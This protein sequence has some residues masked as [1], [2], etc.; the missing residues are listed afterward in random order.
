MNLIMAKMI[1]KY[2][3]EM[4]DQGLNWHDDSG[5]G[6]QWIKPAFRV[7]VKSRY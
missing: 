4:V 2:D 6:T 1:F 3:L 7:R 5:M